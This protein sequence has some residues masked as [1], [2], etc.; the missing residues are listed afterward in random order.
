VQVSATSQVP[1]EARQTVDE[2][3]KSSVG[4]FALAPLHIS[5]GSH[6]PPARHT[7]PER[8]VLA[9]QSSP[10]PQR[11]SAS[12]VPPAPRQ[13]KVVGRTVSAG[14]LALEPL[15]VSATSQTPRASRQM[16]TESKRSAGH[17]VAPPHVSCASQGPMAALQTVA[18]GA[19][20]TARQRV[21]PQEKAPIS[22]GFPVE[23][24]AP[25]V[26]AEE[27]APRPSQLPAGQAVPVV[28]KASGAQFS[29]PVVQRSATSH[30]PVAARHVVV[31]G[32]STSGG[33]SGLVPSQVSA[34]SQ[35]P[36]DGRHGVPAGLPAQ[37]TA[38]Q[39]SAQVPAQQDSPIAHAGVRSQ[40]LATHIAVS[41]AE[42]TQVVALHTGKQPVVGSA[43][44][45]VGTQALP[46]QA[47][48]FAS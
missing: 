25:G 46:G 9:G 13:T 47:A 6:S 19:A 29:V 5:A 33:H 48:S 40:R 44:G 35:A 43:M 39:S 1:P 18:A 2:L 8:K 27:H 17:V 32:A 38:P 45:S 3:E 11:S 22:Q 20:P 31:E 26:Q 7:V 36:A 15:Q 23:Q 42:A 21:G 12:H 28:V 30:G 34:R 41:H 14:Q 10:P 16:L 37:G 24:A 4:Q